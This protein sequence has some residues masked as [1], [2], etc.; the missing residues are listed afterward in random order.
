MGLFGAWA[1]GGGKFVYDIVGL[2]FF[3][4]VGEV[5]SDTPRRIILIFLP[6]TL[7]SPLEIELW[8]AEF[9]SIFHIH[10]IKQLQYS[11]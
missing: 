7:F 10:C 9:M 8:N 2:F 6:R 11:K 4:C 3:S 5:Y 1:G